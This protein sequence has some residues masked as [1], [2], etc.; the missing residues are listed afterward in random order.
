MTAL[1]LSLLPSP[2]GA[3]TYP[4]LDKPAGI[5]VHGPGGVLAQARERLGA[6]L[7]LVHRLDRITSGALLL[8]RGDEAL[9]AAHA[10]WAGKVTKTYLALV[11]GTPD[12]PEGVV[13]APLLENR[14]T[15]PD[16]LRRALRAAYGPGRA[17]RL[18]S[19]QRVGGL[20]PVPP[21]GTTAVHPK[22][23]PAETGYRVVASRGELCL[24]AC[25]PRT[26]RMHQL[27]V[28]LLHL[29][30]PVAFD[31]LYDPA[32]VEGAPRP[33]LHSWRLEWRDP[34][35]AAEGASWTWEAPASPPGGGWGMIRP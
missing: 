30:T 4:A 34:P 16:L 31:P 24:V 27:R 6:E 8:A 25:R 2:P 20:P 3:E 1:A 13:T 9:A 19:G 21:P 26:G 22:G 35:G 14:S 28:H 5:A 7:S 23:R 29:G 10:A 17:G 12:P 18:L 15:R 32:W 11:R 33:F